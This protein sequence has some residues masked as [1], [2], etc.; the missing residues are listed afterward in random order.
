MLGIVITIV[1]GESSGW[2]GIELSTPLIGL[3]IT[4]D[5]CPQTE[6]GI[7]QQYVM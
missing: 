4:V 6:E 7:G 5:H 1:V 3:N 2:L